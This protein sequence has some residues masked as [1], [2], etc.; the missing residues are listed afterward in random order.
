MAAYTVARLAAEWGCSRMHIYNLIDVGKLKSFSISQD[1]SAVNKNGVPSRKGTRILEQEVKRWEDEQRRT[2]TASET[3]S[4]DDTRASGSQI[5]KLA[6]S[7][8]VR[9]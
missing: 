8:S 2:A 1:D 4:S 6:K 5:S 9:A 3:L 7:G